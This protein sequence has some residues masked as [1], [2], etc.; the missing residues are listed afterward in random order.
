MPIILP[1]ALTPPEIRVLQEFRRLASDTLP[2][3]T[4]VAIRHPAGGGEAPVGLLAERGFLQADPGGE[5]F[6][7]TDKGREFL[8]IEAKPDVAEPVEASASTAPE[9]TSDG[10]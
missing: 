6:T 8:A 7:V 5:S 3:A 4:L 9:G 2:L 10:A 1:L